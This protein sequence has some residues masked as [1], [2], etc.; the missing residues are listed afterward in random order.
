MPVVVDDGVVADALGLDP[1][2][3]RAERP[4]ACVDGDDAVAFASGFGFRP[5]SDRRPMRVVSEDD[6]EEEIAMDLPI[7]DRI[8]NA[9]R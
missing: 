3:L 4:R 6:G 8:G 9:P 5:T 1:R 2:P 7:A